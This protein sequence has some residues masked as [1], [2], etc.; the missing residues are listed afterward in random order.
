MPICEIYIIVRDGPFYM[1]ENITHQNV[2]KSIMIDFN[3]VFFDTL[4][5]EKIVYFE[6][7]YNIF[8]MK[9]Y[10]HENSLKSM[11]KSSDIF[12]QL[13]LSKKL[14]TGS[15]NVLWL[16]LLNQ[17]NPS[18]KGSSLIGSSKKIT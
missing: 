14:N 2:T 4:L 7:I 3:P 12:S 13:I 10:Y 1:I 9:C 8:F 17:I 16:L 15:L 18:R 5:S 11:L 6:F